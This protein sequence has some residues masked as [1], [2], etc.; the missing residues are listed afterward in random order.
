MY[1][2][3]EILKVV[4]VFLMLLKSIK[5]HSVLY[6]VLQVAT[7]EIGD[8]TMKLKVALFLLLMALPNWSR[9]IYLL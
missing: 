7:L 3:H 1:S 9:I 5:L 2:R 4:F 8:G 6:F